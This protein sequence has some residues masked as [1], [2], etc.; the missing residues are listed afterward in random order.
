M[1]KYNKKTIKVFKKYYNLTSYELK[2]I[3]KLKSMTSVSLKLNGKIDLTVNEISFL[4]NES[5]KI[6][7]KRTQKIN[8][9]KLE[10]FTPQDFY[11]SL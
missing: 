3:L 2:N 11:I 10:T 9:L 4:C 7:K 8:V 6:E 1:I 5:K